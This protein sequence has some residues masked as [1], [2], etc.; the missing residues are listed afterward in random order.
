ML[1]NHIG[2]GLKVSTVVNAAKS[3]VIIPEYEKTQVSS[4][5][6]F[7]DVTKEPSGCLK[8]EQHPGYLVQK[9]NL[10]VRR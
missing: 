7:D 10:D 1:G 6:V 5:D 2:I 3:G 8:K 4:R 9:L